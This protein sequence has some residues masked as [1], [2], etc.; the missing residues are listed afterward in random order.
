[1]KY[2]THLAILFMALGLSACDRPSDTTVVVPTAVPGPPG[3]QGATGEQGSQG[4][5]GYT[6]RQGDAGYT[7]AE[8]AAGATGATGSTGAQVKTGE[9]T[10][11]IV[12]PPAE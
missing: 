7:G 5:T 9:G 10:T 1:M 3:P 2:S 12:A 4:Y 6:G 8:G 11:I